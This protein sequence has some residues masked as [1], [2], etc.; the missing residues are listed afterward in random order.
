M[1][2]LSKDQARTTYA[3]GL[4][5]L[6]ANR[7]L[8]ARRHFAAIAESF[9][10]AAEAWYQMGLID[11]AS[12]RPYTAAQCFEMALRSKPDQYEILRELELVA[13]RVGRSDYATDLN[14]RMVKLRPDDPAPLV[15]M[16]LTTQQSGAFKKAETLFRRAQKKWP[17][18]GALYR[19]WFRGRTFKTASDPILKQALDL[20]RRDDLA[21]LERMSL[22]FALAKAME[23]LGRHDKVFHFLRE[24]NEIGRALYPFDRAAR[25]RQAEAYFAA[26]SDRPIARAG[27]SDFAPV[28][29]IGVPRSGTTLVER[30]ISAHP[31]VSA[32]G[33]ISQA[34]AFHTALMRRGEEIEPVAKVDPDLLTAFARQYEVSAREIAQAETGRVTDKSIQNNLIVGWLAAAF[35]KARFIMVRRDP[36]DVA[37]SIYKNFFVPGGHTYSYDLGD[38]ASVIRTFDLSVEHWRERVDLTEVS[39][40][41]LIADPDAQSRRLIAAAGLDWDD[42]C[43]EFYKQKSN[44]TTLSLAQVRQPIY[45]SSSGGWKRYETEMQP[46]I[47]AWEK[48]Q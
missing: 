23:D 15:N 6:K 34:Y 1:T 33:E 37:L 16:G 48:E 5:L 24:G 29:V 17:H 47:D 30:I 43:L 46:F 2:S 19:I 36:R 10:K 3:K 31:D 21:D 14:R 13:R 20:W 18:S 9:P 12:G 38:I 28:F 4:E 7:P 44:V 45:K 8:E 35:P 32:G 22:A 42:A 26:A 27:S 39:Y 11:N 25:R 41:D 40:D